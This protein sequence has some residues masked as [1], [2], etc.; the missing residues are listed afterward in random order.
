M[1]SRRI[2]L[3]LQS[4]KLSADQG[5]EQAQRAYAQA[6]QKGEG[7]AQNASEAARYLKLADTQ[8]VS[9]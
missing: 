5:N 7:V 1:E 9:H 6:L 2:W 8:L 4:V 3:R